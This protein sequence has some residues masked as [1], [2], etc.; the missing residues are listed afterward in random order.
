MK[1]QFM[2]LVLVVVTASFFSSCKSKGDFPGRIFMP[3]MNYS[4][5]YEAYASTKYQY[6]SAN[7]SISAIEPIAGTIPRRYL[8]NSEEV[9][10]NDAKLMAYLFKNYFKN[11]IEHPEL[12]N[13]QRKLAAVML[14]NPIMGSDKVLAEGKVK[15]DIYCAVCH[16]KKGQAD[17]TVITLPD[18][19]DGP[20]TS[21]PPLFE[22]RIVGMSDGELFYS[23]SYGK[24]MMGGYYSQLSPEDR[25]KVLHYIK[26]LAGIKETNT[27]TK[28]EVDSIDVS[29]GSQ[30]DV[31]NIYYNVG[32]AQLR[33]ESEYILDQLVS[34]FDKNP[35]VVVEIGSHADSRGDFDKNMVLSNDRANSVVTYLTDHGVQANQLMAKGYGVTEPAVDCGEN[36]TGADHQKNRRT[37]FKI[38]NVN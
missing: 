3:D 30:F 5:A 16:G 19:S 35:N 17:G 6:Q 23:I 24:N 1:K 14:Q 37:T 2:F 20:F 21:I 28:I 38:L 34:F 18:G 12:D 13:E 8:P 15:Y 10:N 29:A 22:N 25:W 9:V 4:N 7:D 31:P 32:S 26:S 36:C 27:L 11:P 33:P